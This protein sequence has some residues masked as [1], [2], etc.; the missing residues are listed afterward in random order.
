MKI[1]SKSAYKLIYCIIH[2]ELI[3]HAAI[4]YNTVSIGI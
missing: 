2:I 1:F 3:N 4:I